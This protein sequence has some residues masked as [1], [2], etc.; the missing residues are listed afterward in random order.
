MNRSVRRRESGSR[1][2][3]SGRLSGT[4]ASALRFSTRL[5]FSDTISQFL[6]IEDERKQEDGADRQ[7]RIEEDDEG[8]ESISSS[9]EEEEEN[10]E[11][12]SQNKRQSRA[13]TASM[14]KMTKSG[15]RAIK[16]SKVFVFAMLLVVAT[17]ILVW[18]YIFLKEEAKDD[19]EFG[20]SL[21]LK[22]CD[23]I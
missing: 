17:V 18:T 15:S 23:L 6:N 11:K 20:V 7:E 16:W 10:R 12:R 5:Q 2:R 13:L 8:V 3:S 19:F 1:R 9:E 21:K 22:C 14:V 4:G